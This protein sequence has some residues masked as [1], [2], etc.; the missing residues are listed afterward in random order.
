MLGRRGW[1]EYVVGGGSRGTLASLAVLVS[2]WGGCSAGPRGLC[3][4]G[5]AWGWGSA[6]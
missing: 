2:M 4:G 3:A 1:G 6:D 5:G